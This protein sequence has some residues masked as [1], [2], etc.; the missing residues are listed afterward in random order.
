MKV[1]SGSSEVYGTTCDVRK[2][3]DID[4]AVDYFVQN[5]GLIDVLINGA[6]G[7]FLAPFDSI[8][9]NG[10][11]TVIDI[12]LMGTFYVTKSV[13]AKCLKGRG[14]NIINISSTL[15]TCGVALYEIINLF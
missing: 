14:G 6:A 3:E 1:E 11:K 12:D 4:K 15:Q 5:V 13:Y 10:F 9:P 8:T 2:V 7:N